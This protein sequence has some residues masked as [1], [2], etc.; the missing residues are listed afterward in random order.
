M[1]KKSRDVD[2]MTG[3]KKNN[4]KVIGDGS[5]PVRSGKESYGEEPPFYACDRKRCLNGRCGVC[6][7]VILGLGIAAGICF[8][9]IFTGVL[10]FSFSTDGNETLYELICS[11]CTFEPTA[12]PTV[13]P[14]YDPTSIPTASPTEEPT[15]DP[16][17]V[18]SVEPTSNPTGTPTLEPS[19]VPS[20]EPTKAPTGQPSVDPTANPTAPTYEPTSAPTG[21]PT[22]DPSAAPTSPTNEPTSAPTAE[23]TS[24]RRL[25]YDSKSTP[26]VL[27]IIANDIESLEFQ[28]PE[29]E[30]FLSEGYT[31]KNLSSKISQKSL[32]TGKMVP[33][34]KGT[35]WLEQLK[36]KGY[37]NHYYGD[38]MSGGMI[39]S[40][41]IDGRGWDSYGDLHS[42]GEK[43]LEEVKSAIR[44]LTGEMWSI[45]VSLTNTDPYTG[46][47]QHAK[48][49]TVF[50]ACSRYFSEDG[51]DYDHDRGVNCQMSMKCDEKF[52]DVI[53]TLKNTELW[54]HT[55][56]FLVINGEQSN[57]FSISGGYLPAKFLSK[58]NNDR[59]SFLDI[60]PSILSVAGFS[61]SQLKS[62][63]LDGVPIVEINTKLARSLW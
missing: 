19:G 39:E 20:V 2:K 7:L 61:D 48:N 6:W 47:S 24:E 11:D 15:D 62:L 59:R 23:P 32:M 55:M 22:L 46:F 1:P 28:T 41:K 8:L 31:F 13:T 38:W 4:Y 56:V 42:R 12:D 54:E 40:W 35:T 49:A 26:N 36:S 63:K 58:T 60:V 29:I 25:L 3:Q 53:K 5:K 50:E 34:D 21:E 10:G 14:T 30:R 44:I 52:G 16:T 18:P 17:G 57:M 37:V 27:L 9:F 33:R 45:T 51:S 43:I